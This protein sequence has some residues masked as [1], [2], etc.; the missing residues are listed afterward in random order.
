M[1]LESR[2]EMERLLM[3]IQLA[4]EEYF[5]KLASMSDVPA[6]LLCDR[7]VMDAT[8]YITAEERN[9]IF[10]QEQWKTVKLRD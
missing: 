7:G 1:G 10:D 9:A 3:R 6:L 2:L 4:M 5:L 8:A